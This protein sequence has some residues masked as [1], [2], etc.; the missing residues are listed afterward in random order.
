MNERIIE[1]VKELQQEI[2]K[3]N[4]I[5]RQ[6]VIRGNIVSVADTDWLILK[7]E[8]NKVYCLHKD[9]IDEKQFD[10][11][12]NDWRESELREFLNSD[13]YNGLAEKV[14]AGNIL[15]VTTDLTSLD[16]QKEYG[17][18]EDYVSLLTVD[19][20]R[21]NRDILP[22]TDEWWWL[23]TPHSTKCNDDERWICV[24]SPRGYVIGDDCFSNFGVRPFCI[25]D[26]SIFKS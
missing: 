10:D 13:F 4:K 6:E 16:G 9:F 26:S 5:K 18:A 14:G 23:S 21:K 1:L 11:D 8:D 7:I 12:C 2:D 22:N 24:V 25:F 3:E 19:L 20:Y 15:P 17:N